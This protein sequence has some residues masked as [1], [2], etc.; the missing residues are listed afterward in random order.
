M[1][2]NRKYYYL[3]LKENYF[4]DD[5]DRIIPVRRR[6]T[7]KD[8]K[9]KR[10]TTAGTHTGSHRKRANTTKSQRY[11][12]YGRCRKGLYGGSCFGGYRKREIKKET[13][14]GAESRREG[15]KS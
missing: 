15:Q 2:D 4:D 14:T 10:I 12:F 11:L 7:G 13:E 3:K 5:Q 8:R 9:K 6:I 1:S